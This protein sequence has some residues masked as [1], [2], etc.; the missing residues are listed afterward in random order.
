MLSF[1]AISELAISEIPVPAPS[2]PTGSIA[3][4]ETPDDVWAGSATI[5]WP[6]ITGTVAWTEAQDVWAATGSPIFPTITAQGAWVE[7]PDL[8]AAAGTVAWPTITAAGAWVEG[9]DGLAA[10]ATLGPVPISAAATWTEASDQWAVVATLS[11]SAIAAAGAWVE[12]QDAWAVLGTG[13][14]IAAI[15]WNEAPDRWLANGAGASTMLPGYNGVWSISISGSVVAGAG[16]DPASRIL[17]VFYETNVSVDVPC[18]PWQ[19]TN[20][21]YTSANPQAYCLQLVAQ[22]L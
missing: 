22:S 12:S 2:G 17:R 5:S 8:W 20:A 4:V 9:A 15:A 13:P 3:I 16:Y 19:V 6:A 21:I 10:V 18:Q 11:F 14:I 1:G 7:G